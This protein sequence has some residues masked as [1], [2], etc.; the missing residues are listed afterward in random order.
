MRRAL[1]LA[2]A[3]V[4]ACAHAPS[5]RAAVVEAEGWAPLGADGAPG[6]RRRALAD[7]ERAAVEKVSGVR[8]TGRTRVDGDLAV[9]QTVETRASGTVRRCEVL[10][11]SDEGGF[12]R[13]RVRAWVAP[14]PLAGRRVAV[15]LSGPGAKSAAAGARKSLLAGGFS[16]ADGKGADLELDGEVSVRALGTLD[17]FYSRRARVSLSLRRPSNGSVLAEESREISAVDAA[18]DAAD[19]RAAELAGELGTARLLKGALARLGD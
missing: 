14:G 8:V 5:P 9:A 1:L 18:P 4:A 6:A 16:V 19:A 15:R 12:H 2:A 7:A 10:S 11:E 13:V 3:L 17:G